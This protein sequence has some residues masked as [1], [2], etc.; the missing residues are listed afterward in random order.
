MLANQIAGDASP[1][2]PVSDEAQVRPENVEDVLA[3]LGAEQEAEAAPLGK[4]EETAAS[5]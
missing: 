2:G 3:M 4:E 1:L 5:P